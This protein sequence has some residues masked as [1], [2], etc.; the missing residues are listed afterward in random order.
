MGAIAALERWAALDHAALEAAVEARARA[1]AAKLAGL[2][3]LTASVVRDETGN[4]F[5]RVIIAIDPAAAGLAAHD[6]ARAL[7]RAEPRILLRTLYADRG[8]LQMDVRRM[9]D[10]TL[11][12]VCARIAA[13]LRTPPAA[14]APLAA[15]ADQSA[16]AVL[17]WLA[18]G[19]GS[20]ERPRVD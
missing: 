11:E 13:T 9:D 12:M 6:L 7:A 5:S 2:P 17:G 14:R 19:P 10:A 15:P 20:D 4:P 3:G 8:I 1:G 18:D 16:A